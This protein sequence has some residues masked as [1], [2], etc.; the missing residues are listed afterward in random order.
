MD[1]GQPLIPISDNAIHFYFDDVEDESIEFES[2]LLR[3]TRLFSED[4]AKEI[5]QF[6][7]NN[8]GKDILIVHCTM[9]KCRSG[10]VGDFANDFYALDYQTFKKNN[11]RVQPNTHVKKTLNNVY[12]Q[13]E[14][15][16]Y[17]IQRT[18]FD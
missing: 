13:D 8:L 18:R 3:T 17:G 15:Y 9:G 2:T 5:I 4:Q 14:F 6:L 7:E 11:P 10:A 1:D 16:G 12:K